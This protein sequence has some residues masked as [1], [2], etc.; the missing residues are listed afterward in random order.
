MATMIRKKERRFDDKI[1]FVERR[2]GKF[3]MYTE[4]VFSLGLILL[5]LWL[6]K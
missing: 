4:I 5:L 6:L 2:N 1:I 3:W